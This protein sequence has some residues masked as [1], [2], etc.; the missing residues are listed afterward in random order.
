M[1]KLMHVMQQMTESLSLA[2]VVRSAW[3]SSYDAFKL[4]IHGHSVGHA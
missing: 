2:L 3:T 4:D 1:V